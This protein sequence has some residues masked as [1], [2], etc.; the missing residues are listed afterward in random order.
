MTSLTTAPGARPLT[1][2]KRRADFL[3]A[4][5]GKRASSRGVVVQFLPDETADAPAAIGF[6]ASKKVGGAV[7]RNRAKR[8]LRE[9][10]R[11]V[12]GTHARPGLYV[13][14]ARGDTATRDYARLLG[15]LRYA[16]A[17]VHGEERKSQS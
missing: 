2:I 3:R 17:R 5:K 14:I 9:A 16:V 10:A 4:A 1:M 12:L 6:T 13:L 8:R 11:T 7:V 15:D